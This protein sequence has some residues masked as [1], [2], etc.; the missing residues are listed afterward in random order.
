MILSTPTLLLEL[1]MPIDLHP[2]QQ[3]VGLHYA[4]FQLQQEV[5]R[6][7]RLSHPCP[8]STPTQFPVIYKTSKLVTYIIS[9]ITHSDRC[10]HIEREWSANV[11]PAA[12][13]LNRF[14]LTEGLTSADH[15]LSM[16][17]PRSLC[18]NLTASKPV[19][20]LTTI[21]TENTARR[22]LLQWKKPN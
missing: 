15:A 13:N 21:R 16:C 14:L 18:Y 11:K 6:P 5:T 9:N 20:L 7:Y 12:V 19:K 22:S 17:I 2:R 4:V 1:Q 8:L 10:I 3:H